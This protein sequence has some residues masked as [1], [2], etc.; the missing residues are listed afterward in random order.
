MSTYDTNLKLSTE[1]EMVLCMDIRIRII[2]L[3]YVA[4]EKESNA[5]SCKFTC[6]TYIMTLILQD[7]FSE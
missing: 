5:Y 3:S 7:H 4:I 6:K 2:K 1:I